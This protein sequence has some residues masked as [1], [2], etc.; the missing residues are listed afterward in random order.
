MSLEYRRAR[1]TVAPFTKAEH[2]KPAPNSL[3]ESLACGRPVVATPV[4]GLA[5][6]IHEERGG[7]ACSADASALADSLDRLQADW[8]AFSDRA[9]RTAERWFSLEGF[10]G[11]YQRLYGELLASS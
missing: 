1:V 10:L 6:M 4:V 3:V 9:R 2:C 7:I 11:E 5:E 8:P